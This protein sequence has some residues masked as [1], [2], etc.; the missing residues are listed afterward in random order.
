MR[1]ESLRDTAYIF[2]FLFF[3]G[4][5]LD[6]LEKLIKKFG[7]RCMEFRQLLLF[8]LLSRVPNHWLTLEMLSLRTKFVLGKNRIRKG[9]LECFAIPIF[10]Y[11]DCFFSPFFFLLYFI[12]T[13]VSNYLQYA[14][15]ITLYNVQYYVQM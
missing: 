6:R 11:A 8:E 4:I 7:K 12:S 10:L 1:V 5:I 9:Q 14:T 2:F 13:T 3:C 15:N